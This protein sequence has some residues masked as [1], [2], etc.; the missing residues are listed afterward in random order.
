MNKSAAASPFHP[1]NRHQGRY[2]FAALIAAHPP[3]ADKVRPNGYGELS[4]AFDDAQAVRLL[5]QALLKL[6][7]NLNWQLPE[8]Y[9]TPPVPG[10]ADYVHALADLL[11]SDN[12]G[13][14]PRERDIMDIGCGANCIYPLIGHAEYGWR[15]TGTDT[16]A[17]AI[18][19]ASQIIASNPGLQRGIRLRRQ[20]QAG[21]IFSGVVHK[22]ERYHAV[23]CNPPFHASA[24]EAAAGSQRKVRNLGLKRDTPLNFGGQHNELW[25]EGGEQAFIGQMIE[26]SAQYADRII[27]FTSLVSRK[28]HLPALRDRLKA[29][30]AYLVRI[31]D[32]AQGQKQSRFLAWT[33][34]PPATRAQRMGR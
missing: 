12:G 18:T 29:I 15:F 10:R 6:F 19:A 4:I 27:W 34:M 21:A 8:G 25:C 3:L 20:K 24:A 11:A 33:F 2:D 32:M 14:I 13:A 31:I 30:D 17:D 23:M 1:R 7:Y 26:E 5:N 16:S 22:N 9:L 28:E